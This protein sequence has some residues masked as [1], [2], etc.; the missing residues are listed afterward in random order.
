MFSDPDFQTALTH[1]GWQTF[2]AAAQDVTAMA[3]AWLRPHATGQEARLAASLGAIGAY[4]LDSAEAPAD[5]RATLDAARE[6]LPFHL[7]A[8]QS[9]PPVSADRLKLRAQ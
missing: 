7:E 2:A 8:L 9:A 5:E 6:A 1:C 4:V 3:E